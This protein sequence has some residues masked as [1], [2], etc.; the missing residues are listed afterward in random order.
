MR[1]SQERNKLFKFYSLDFQ[2]ALSA[3]SIAVIE[4]E[5]VALMR[6]ILYISTRTQEKIIL[7]CNQMGGLS[8]LGALAAL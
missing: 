3:F 1:E 4:K 6:A 8:C 7:I 2:E 5:T